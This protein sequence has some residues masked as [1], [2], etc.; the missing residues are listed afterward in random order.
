MANRD[1]KLLVYFDDEAPLVR[2]FGSAVISCWDDLSPDLRRKL[3]DQ[4]KRVMEDDDPDLV[5]EQMKRF[6]DEHTGNH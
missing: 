5:D 4:A 1:D 2:R 6:I 3:M